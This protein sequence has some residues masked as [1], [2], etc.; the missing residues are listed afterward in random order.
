M[1]T[2]SLGLIA[3]SGKASGLFFLEM[4]VGVILPMFLLSSQ[5]IQK[6]ESGILFAQFLVIGGIVLN[7][8]NVLFFAQ[9]GEGFSYMPTLWEVAVTIGLISLGIFLYRFAIVTWPALT[10]AEAD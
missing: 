5:G 9:G 7:R 2:G 3:S 4:A 10:H 1:S 6:S 8:F